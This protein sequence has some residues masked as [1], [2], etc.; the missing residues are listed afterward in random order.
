MS[1]TQTIPYGNQL[2]LNIECDFSEDGVD[3]QG[4]SID[5]VEVLSELDKAFNVG[6]DSELMK[7]DTYNVIINS[8]E[9]DFNGNNIYWILDDMFDMAR[10]GSEDLKTALETMVLAQPKEDQF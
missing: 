4:A 3:V 8:L 9:V 7:C 2:E 1:V 5:G 6:K 10:A